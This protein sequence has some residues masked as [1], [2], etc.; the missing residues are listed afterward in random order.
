MKTRLRWAQ[1]FPRTGCVLHAAN[2]I[3]IGVGRI[4]GLFGHVQLENKIWRCSPLEV[5]IIAPESDPIQECA[6]SG[7][8]S[9]E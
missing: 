7:A 4:K 6:W 5:L 9:I 3:A 8:L 1:P 2:E